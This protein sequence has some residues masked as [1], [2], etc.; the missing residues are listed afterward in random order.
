MYRRQHINPNT[1]VPTLL[2][3]NKGDFVPEMKRLQLYNSLQLEVK[4]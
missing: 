1:R 4:L 2:R 3:Y